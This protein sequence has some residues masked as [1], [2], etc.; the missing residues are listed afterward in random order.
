M[1][2]ER[3]E[4]AGNCEGEGRDKKK[5]RLPCILVPP[6][7][8]CGDTGGDCSLPR[9]QAE[10]TCPLTSSPA[11]PPVGDQHLGK[12]QSHGGQGSSQVEG[13]EGMLQRKQ[14]GVRRSCG[15]RPQGGW[16][17]EPPGTPW[18]PPRLPPSGAQEEPHGA[19]SCAGL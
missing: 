8:V 15:W 6:G 4:R 17:P 5:E 12:M 13:R 7:S 18:V 2:Y 1:R 14:G 10:G 19:S 16:L 11:G 9:P 3:K